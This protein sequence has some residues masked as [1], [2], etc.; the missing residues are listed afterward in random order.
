M[1]IG[2]RT[3]GYVDVNVDERTPAGYYRFGGGT[4]G[5][6]GNDGGFWGMAGCSI[7]CFFIEFC[8][9]YRK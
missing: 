1:D 6:G 7:C 4:E 3:C 2:R 8:V 9:W 5:G